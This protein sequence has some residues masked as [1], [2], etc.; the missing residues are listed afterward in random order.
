M[1]TSGRFSSQ[2]LSLF[3]SCSTSCVNARFVCN[4][5]LSNLCH[6]LSKSAV[7]EPIP[8]NTVSKIILSIINYIVYRGEMA[9]F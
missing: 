2:N 9:V 5:F 4:D 1:R 7:L 3:Y 8:D 6:R